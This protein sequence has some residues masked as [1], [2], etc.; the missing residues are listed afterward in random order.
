MGKQRKLTFLIVVYFWSF[1]SWFSVFSAGKDGNNGL[2][3]TKVSA[4]KK[5][6]TVSSTTQVGF[7]QWCALFMDRF[8]PILSYTFLYFLIL[9][10][11]FLYFLIRSYAFL[12]FLILSYTFL[13]FGIVKKKESKVFIPNIC[14]FVKLWPRQETTNEDIFLKNN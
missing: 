9:S 10:Y 4:R 12:Y 11:T 1:L 14:Y 3:S 6:I 7:N 8:L 2:T 5:S 13:K